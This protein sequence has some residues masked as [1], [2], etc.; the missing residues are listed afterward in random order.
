MS[1]TV[2]RLVTSAAL[3]AGA[4]LVPA[5]AADICAENNYAFFDYGVAPLP[6][7]DIPDF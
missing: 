7:S 4:A 3:C 5:K 2:S 6:R 1:A